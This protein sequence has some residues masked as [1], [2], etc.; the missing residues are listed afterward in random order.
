LGEG[1]FLRAPPCSE[2]YQTTEQRNA[3]VAFTYSR[4]HICIL[5][6]EDAMKTSTAR[7]LRI[8]AL[9]VMAGALSGCIIV[10]PPYHYHPW[11]GYAR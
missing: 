9:A 11:Y 10:P 1:P 8:A 2:L 7:L 3:P 5:D 4:C 6:M